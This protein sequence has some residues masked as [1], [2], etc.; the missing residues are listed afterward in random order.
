MKVKILKSI[1]KII[2][3]IKYNLRK[4][5]IKNFDR[6]KNIKKIKLNK[7][8]KKYSLIFLSGALF[9]SLRSNVCAQNLDELMQNAYYLTDKRK[10]FEILSQRLLEKKAL[11]KALHSLKRAKTIYNT[12]RDLCS[13]ISVFSITA[14]CASTQVSPKTKSKLFIFSSCLNGIS[15]IMNNLSIYTDNKILDFLDKH[16]DL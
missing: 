8:F 7:K 15:L 1:M 12:G 13:I 5:V 4:N 11:L 14:T 16:K 3:L 9:L 10:L 6:I 2:M